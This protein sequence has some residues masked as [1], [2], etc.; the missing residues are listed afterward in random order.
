MTKLAQCYL[1]FKTV[2]PD[3]SSVIHDP[4][5]NFRPIIKPKLPLFSQNLTDLKCIQ[6]S[7]IAHRTSQHATLAVLVCKCAP[8]NMYPLISNIFYHLGIC[9]KAIWAFSYG[10]M[11]ELNGIV[12]YQY[13]LAR[14]LS[15]HTTPGSRDS[16]S[17]SSQNH[18]L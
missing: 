13:S 4:S 1:L 6:M 5:P 9:L 2:Y 14:D 8:D 15:F 16:P 17:S 18:G 3:I 7:N 10:S 12:L 11:H